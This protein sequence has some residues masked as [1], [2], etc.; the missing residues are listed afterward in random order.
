MYICPECGEF[1][2]DVPDDDKQADHG[3]HGIWCY[4][5]CQNCGVEFWDHDK[6]IEQFGQE[7]L[8]VNHAFICNDCG[9]VVNVELKVDIPITY[10]FAPDKTFYDHV[11]KSCADER[12][13]SQKCPWCGLPTKNGEYCSKQCHDEDYKANHVHDYEG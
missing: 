2:L 3:E 1:A 8:E 13:N 9:E 5:Q 11:C 10:E 12:N 7:F 6:D 4:F